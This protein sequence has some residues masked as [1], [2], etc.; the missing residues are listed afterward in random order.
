M[1]KAQVL[2]IS[3][4]DYKY[5]QSIT[6]QRTIQA[7]IAERAK[8]LI[9]KAQ[10]ESNH[11]VAERIDINTIK[12]CIKKYKQGASKMPFMIN[13][14]KDVSLKSQTMPNHGLWV[15]HARNPV[16]L[17]MQLNCGHWL[18]CISIFRPTLLNPNIQD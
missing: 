9:Y 4:E 10:G 2:E 18:H 7:Q 14:G 8:I 17:A 11:A 3:D 12:L 6:R 15:L 1:A 5:L 13:T 16:N